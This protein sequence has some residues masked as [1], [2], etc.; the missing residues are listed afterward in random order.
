[1]KK[2]LPLLAFF[3]CFNHLSAQPPVDTSNIY[4]SGTA[5]P[6]VKVMDT[7]LVYI[8]N[9]AANIWDNNYLTLYYYN[10]D[11]NNRKRVG[12]R[13]DNSKYMWMN[14]YQ[15]IL[16]YTGSRVSEQLSQT[17]SASINNWVNQSLFLTDYDSAGNKTSTLSQSWDAFSQGW[18]NSG[19]HTFTYDMSGNL[20]GDLLESWNTFTTM[21]DNS[22]LTTIAYNEYGQDTS[23]LLQQWDAP[24]SSWRNSSLNSIR[25]DTVQQQAESLLQSWDTISGSWINKG[26]ENYT[27]DSA[28]HQVQSLYRIWDIEHLEWDSSLFKFY[29][30]YP[31]GLLSDFYQKT[32]D[33]VSQSWI[34]KSYAH[35]DYDDDGYR[36]SYFT[37][38]WDRL[39]ESWMNSSKFRYTYITISYSVDEPDGYPCTC[40]F[41]NPLSLPGVI[42]CTGFPEKGDRILRLYDFTGQLVYQ[43]KMT[44]NGATLSGLSLRKGMYLLTVEAGHQV[45][46]V[47]KLLITGS[48]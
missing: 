24:A 15:V 32:W 43:A 37:E 7:S 27:H 39:S 35:Y 1:M 36:T 23:T 33:D 38:V 18:V 47:N 2:I 22:T 26:I 13:W 44:G 48:H 11:W 30:Y 9:K 19:R 31:S 21:W 4:P 34:N 6:V 25:Y 8:W 40:I 46:Y 14:D 42:T 17:W 28:G 12:K 10:E 41:Q 20:T 3:C 16:T 5:Y 45:I 29:Q